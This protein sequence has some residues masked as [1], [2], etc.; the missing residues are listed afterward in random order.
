VAPGL[1]NSY[2]LLY[3]DAVMAALP[4]G[5]AAI[6]RAA[7][8]GSASVVPG[9]WAGDQPQEFVGLQRAIVSGE[10]AAMSGFPT[11]GSDVGGYAGPPFD[12]TD[13]F[14]RWAQLGAVSPV[15]EVGGSGPN[16]T[17]WTLGTEAMAGL[18]SSAVLHYELFPYLYGLLRGHQPVLRPLGYS[19]PNDPGSWGA[20]FEFTVGPDLLAAPVTG[21][22]TTPSVY[23]PPGK[24]VDLYA[25]TVVDGGGSAFVRQTPLDQ[26]PF[27][28]KLGSVLPFNLRTATGSWWGVNE[29][30]HP[31]HAGYLA[32]SGATL[33]LTGQ[34]RDVQIFVPATARPSGV[35]IGGHAVPWRWNAGPLPGAVV[36]VHGPVV[37]G[38]IAL[39]S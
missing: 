13:L 10:T 19:F 12:N 26:F 20:T 35:T 25:G 8:V 32:T 1:T 34:P 38:E 15:M 24:W 6:F 16:A 14:V 31:G 28:V 7:T 2:P 22:G 29:Q 21:P 18:R 27:Y 5:D 23:L 37:K 30:T 33:E 39:V 17:P 11:W 9:L 3:A 4:K 36:R